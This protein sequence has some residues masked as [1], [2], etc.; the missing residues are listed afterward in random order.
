LSSGSPNGE[1]SPEAEKLKSGGGKVLDPLSEESA[2]SV[3]SESSDIKTRRG[4]CGLSNQNRAKQNLKKFLL[5]YC[6]MNR[7]ATSRVNSTTTFFAQTASFSTFYCLIII[8]R[9]LK[10]IARKQKD[11]FRYTLMES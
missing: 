11:S 4:A 2:Y 3:L 7:T 5:N 8:R 1:V 9:G 10:W 6:A